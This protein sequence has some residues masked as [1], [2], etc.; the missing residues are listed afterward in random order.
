MKI[1]LTTRNDNGPLQV[2]DFN[3]YGKGAVA[4]LEGIAAGMQV[5][6]AARLFFDHIMVKE[7]TG[8]DVIDFIHSLKAET[9]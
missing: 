3:A 7:G 5:S 8:R 6:C 1:V 2:A 9:L 4:T